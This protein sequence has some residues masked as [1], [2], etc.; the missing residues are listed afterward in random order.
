MSVHLHTLTECIPT[1]GMDTTSMCRKLCLPILASLSRELHGQYEHQWQVAD[2]WFESK[3]HSSKPAHQLYLIW[4]Q[5]YLFLFIS[6]E[7]VE[8]VFIIMTPLFANRELGI[9]A[10]VPV[11]PYTSGHLHSH[12][13]HYH[14]PPRLQHYSFPL[15]VRETFKT[16]ASLSTHDNR[17][18][19][20]KVRLK[21]IVLAPYW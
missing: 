8:T 5:V 16:H 18:F 12:L 2:G 17:S 4:L 3:Y 20:Y 21:L 7:V 13:P 14:T 1:M 11:A 15:M 10:G 6:T 19:S 9:E